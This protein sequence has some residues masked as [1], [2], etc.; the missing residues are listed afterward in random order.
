MFQYIKEYIEK[1]YTQSGED[2]HEFIYLYVQ[3]HKCT[4]P[5][6]ICIPVTQ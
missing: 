1:R 3:P 4:P 6:T 5:L 2:L